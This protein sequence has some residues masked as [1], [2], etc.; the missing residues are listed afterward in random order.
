MA[1]GDDEK[2]SIA[3]RF[4]DFASDVIGSWW[5]I[6]AQ[7]LAILTWFFL[8][9]WPDSPTGH[10]D[11]RTFD[12]LRL[13]LA[14]Q[15]A[16]T[17]PL[18]LMAQRRQARKDRKVLYEIDGREREAATIRKDAQERRARLEEKVDRLLDRLGES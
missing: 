16:Y 5:M 18:I 12:L 4:T 3:Q 7:T 8:N 11:D 1:S 9:L 13:L 10:F 17:A 2:L 6:A 15:S 14:F